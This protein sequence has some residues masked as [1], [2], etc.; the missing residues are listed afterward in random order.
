MAGMK[1]DDPL[2]CGDIPVSAEYAIA[3]PGK[4][5]CIGRNYREHAKELGNDVPVEPLFFLKPSTSI[6][7]DG[8]PIVLPRQS[9]RVEFE[10]EIGIV[11]GASN[12][13]RRSWC[14]SYQRCHCAR[15]SEKRQS[16]DSRERIRFFLSHRRRRYGFR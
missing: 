2:T 11:I 15:P 3:R 16:M 14:R 10:G 7:G 13:G 4:I 6:I 9:E 12:E 8:D 1:V 5:V